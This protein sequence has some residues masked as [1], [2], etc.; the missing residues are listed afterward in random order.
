MG[1]KV[2]RASENSRAEAGAV[3]EPPASPQSGRKIVAHGASRGG[4]TPHLARAP[5]G[6]KENTAKANGALAFS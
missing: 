4:I 2:R 5:L 1:R 6:A 3:R